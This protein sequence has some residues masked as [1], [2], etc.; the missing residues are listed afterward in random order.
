MQLCIF[1][2]E[3][4]KNYVGNPVKGYTAPLKFE[5]NLLIYD[6]TDWS[7]GAGITTTLELNIETIKAWNETPN[8]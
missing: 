6:K 4:N 1:D 5:N 3:E 7:T 8:N 2:V